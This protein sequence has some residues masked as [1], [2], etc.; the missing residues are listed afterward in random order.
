MAEKKSTK[1]KQVKKK[2]P[3]KKLTTEEKE[4]IKREGELPKKSVIKKETKQLTIFFVMIGVIFAAFLI[5][6]FYSQSLNSFKF[7]NTNWTVE[8]FQDIKMFHGR[9]ASF[10]NPNSYYNLYLR[11]DPRK[12]DVTSTGNFTKFKYNMIISTDYEIDYC[13]DKISSTFATL[14]MFSKQGVG[15]KNIEVA[16][17]N[18]ELALDMNKTL[19]K[20]CSNDPSK[21]TVLVTMGN[22]SSVVQDEND[23][24]CYRITM[25]DCSDESAVEKFMINIVE[26]LGQLREEYLKS[27][28]AK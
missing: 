14:G 3:K 19:L 21:M 1:K 11:N 27:Q 10:A 22:K 2:Q 12:N 28:E 18:E 24:Y 5:P 23:P 13:Y 20:D 26:D 15:I 8:E 16:T 7:I 25:D 4:E 9:F 17:T 6:F